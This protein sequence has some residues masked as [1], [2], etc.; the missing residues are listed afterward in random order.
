MKTGKLTLSILSLMMIAMLGAC[1]NKSADV[2]V[3]QGNAGGQVMVNIENDI[4]I[5]QDIIKKDPKSADALIKL[6]NLLMDNSRFAEAVDAYGK[7]LEITPNDVNVRVDMGT[8]YRRLGKL[9]IT[10]QEYRKALAIDPNHLNA[11]LNLA[12]VLAYD[13]NDKKGGIAE[14]EKYL[15]LAPNAPNVPQIKEEI[16]KL[17][18]ESS[19]K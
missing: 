7:A 15:E 10:V 18:A 9:D 11:H 16:A 8:C 14:L 3:T 12:V 6:G 5:L 1:Q 17:K 2:P 13:F 19:A 4:K